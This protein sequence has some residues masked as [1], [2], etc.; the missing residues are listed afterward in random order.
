M[1][2][3]WL[4]LDTNFPTFTGEESADEKVT[5]VQNYLYMLV[6]MLRYSFRNIDM[7]RNMNKTSV[8]RF[9]NYIT[10]PLY[11][12]ITD[13]EGNITEL[14][15]QAHGLGLRVSNAEGNITQLTVTA[16]GLQSQVS[17]VDGRV[18]TLRQTV[19]GFSLTASN[20]EDFSWLYLTSQGINFGSAKIE[21]TGMV[22]FRALSTPGMTVI[23][24]G[25]ITTGT[26]T[27]INIQGVNITGSNITGG[28]ITGATLNGVT[29]NFGDLWGSNFGS[30][31]SDISNQNNPIIR[32]SANRGGVVISSYGGYGTRIDGG[33][34]HLQP[35]GQASIIVHQGGDV[36]ITGRVHING[37]LM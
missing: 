15:I 10:E 5:T 36:H 24:G 32:L 26:I 7:Q 8:E 23:D 12:R 33:D 17:A 30:L 27:A 28:T 31:Y 11:M 22:T 29:I 18:T 21:F 37:R 6:E 3:N 2:S 16:Q 4:F 35:G 1:P 13:A 19:D 20:G 14:G 25:N 34:I 9:T